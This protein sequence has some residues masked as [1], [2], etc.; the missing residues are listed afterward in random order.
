MVNHTNA[1]V[2]YIPRYSSWLNQVENWFA[3]IQHEIITRGVFNSAKDLEKKLMRYIRQYNKQAAPLK[4][5]CADPTRRI[6]FNSSG[7]TD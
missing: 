6:R 5:K 7:S 4:W 3:H 2:H 1:S